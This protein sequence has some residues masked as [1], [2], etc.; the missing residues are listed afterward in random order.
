MGKVGHA[1]A[2][3]AGDIG[4]DLADDAREPGIEL[5]ERRW[6]RR[7]GRLARAH[8]PRLTFVRRAHSVPTVAA[9][10]GRDLKL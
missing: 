2:P 1:V 5:G 4:D 10:S 6:A 7:R 9:T 8:L 3:P